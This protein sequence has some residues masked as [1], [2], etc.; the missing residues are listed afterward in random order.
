M[1]SAHSM[2][3]KL[4]AVA[5]ATGLLAGCSTPHMPELPA[6]PE[7]PK[8]PGVYRI[9][10]QQGNVVTQDM[11]NRL[12]KGMEKRKVRLVLG[13]PLITDTFNQERWDYL[14]SFQKGGGKRTTRH[15]TLRFKQ[16]RLLSIEGDV[17]TA[18]ER[19]EP[20]PHKETVVTVPARKE[21]GGI[22]K[23]LTP[24][25]LK[26]DTS[27]AKKSDQ[28]APESGTSTTP[29][30]ET[31]SAT[32]PDSATEKSKAKDRSLL[33]RL[34]SGFGGAAE[35]PEGESAGAQPRQDSPPAAGET[36]TQTSAAAAGSPSNAAN[37]E[38]KKAHAKSEDEGFFARLLK[39]FRLPKKDSNPPPEDAP[40]AP[41]TPPSA[42]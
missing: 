10:I 18:S 35:R 34:F 9:D 17:R 39:R 19:H 20:K 16:D 30:T 7:M 6:L 13:T 37:T 3:P 42:D 8:I 15:I 31:A 32:L 2:L 1:P 23:A 33:R 25:F 29:N 21:E 41:P 5:V 22:L 26:K 38:A 14:Y 4:S 27:T 24:G 28:A 11:L 40:D 12:E 36:T